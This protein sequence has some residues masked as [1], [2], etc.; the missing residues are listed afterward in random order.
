[1]IAFAVN[2]VILVVAIVIIALVVQWGLTK[3]GWAVDPTLK[4]ILGLIG[5]II[6]LVFIMNMAGYMVGLTPVH[7]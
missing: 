4:I 2:V 7:R 6:V 1:M 5:F 3:L